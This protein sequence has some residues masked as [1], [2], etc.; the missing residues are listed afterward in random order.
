MAF[1]K[2]L[3]KMQ[4]LIEFQA[5]QNGIKEEGLGELINALGS[6]E[7]LKI[8]KFNDN[9][10]K[11]AAER[12]PEMLSKLNSL[13]VIDISDSL[14]GDKHAITFFKALSVNNFI[15]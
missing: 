14:L 13:E 11:N 8:V 9:L 6:N 4:S 12:L 10:V 3:I 2:L 15:I 7:S 5:F 1:A